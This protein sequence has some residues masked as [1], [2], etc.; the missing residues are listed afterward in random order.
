MIVSELINLGSKTL[1][2]ENISSH[3]LDSELILSKVLN[4]KR[5]NL[6]ISDNKKVT[7][8]S[9]KI[10]NDLIKRRVKKEPLAYI[11][12]KKEFWSKSFLVDR[13]ILIPRPET[14]L[15]VEK[16]A[17][18]FKDKKS[19][20][21][22]IGTG[23]GCILLTLLSEIKKSRGI[24]VDASKK[25]INMALK[26]AK[27]FNL[28]S[29]V[30]FHKRQLNEIF[31]QKFDLI[32]S[33]PPYVCTNQIK[34]LSDDVRKY[35]PRMALDGGNDGLDVIKK[36]IYKSKSILKKKGTL[37]LEIGH[38]Q[39]K[40]VSQILRLQGF[41][42]RFLIKDYRENIRCIITTLN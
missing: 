25:A 10:F 23:S 21:L 19:F 26:N 12:N 37:A 7:I 5:E 9:I 38:G 11:F 15:L 27:K 40:E 14:E 42:D 16:L 6:L 24:G 1:K 34:N 4:E 36:V 22:D 31:G 28:E 29:R 2:K 18:L 20:I 8:D 41:K 32:V 39:Y 17:S 33:N 3:L 35:E 13:G 30:K